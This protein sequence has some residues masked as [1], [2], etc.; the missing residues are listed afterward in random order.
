MR[1]VRAVG[2]AV[3]RA[4]G[5]VVADFESDINES[6]IWQIALGWPPPDEIEWHKAR[7]AR[8]FRCELREIDP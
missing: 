3:R 5:H 1:G 7:G 8:A 2:W 4:D 6:K